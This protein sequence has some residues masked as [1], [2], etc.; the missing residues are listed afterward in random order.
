M[1]RKSELSNVVFSSIFP[2]RKPLP[3]GL[4][5]TN[6]SPCSRAREPR[7]PARFSPI[8]AFALFLLHHRLGPARRRGPHDRPALECNS[9][10]LRRRERRS[11][12]LSCESLYDSAGSIVRPGECEQRRVRGRPHLGEPQTGAPQGADPRRGA[13]PTCGGAERDRTV[14][15][16]LRSAGPVALL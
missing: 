9:R 5:G 1:L 2:V 8:C 4:N 10:T 11:V 15:L 3:R 14:P 6:S 16:S 12:G 13:E 7:L